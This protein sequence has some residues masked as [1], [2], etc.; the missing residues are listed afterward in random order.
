MATADQKWQAGDRKGAI[1]LYRR[2]LEQAGASTDYGQRAQ[3]RIAQGDGGDS[4]ASKAAPA[5]DS[6][7]VP[8]PKPEIDTSDL[9]GVT[10]P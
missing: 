9:P 5:P 1:T 6:A 10:A 2:I 8:P 7:P 3:S 4:G